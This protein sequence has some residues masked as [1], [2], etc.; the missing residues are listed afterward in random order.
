[1]SPSNDPSP[2]ALLPSVDAMLADGR[3]AGLKREPRPLLR[4]WV[5]SSLEEARTRIRA[6]IWIPRDREEAADF[7]VSGILDRSRGSLAMRLR[8]VLNATGILLHTNLGRAVLP[9]AVGRA[10]LAAAGGYSALEIDLSTGERSSRLAALRELIPLMTGAE[11]GFA[12]NN[13]AAALLL[14]MAALAR[15]REVLV[16]RGQLVEIGGSFRLPEILEAAGVILR[17]V[18]TTN[19]TRISD[20]RR[21][22]NER[23]ALVLRVHRSNFR[24][25]GFTEEPALDELAAFCR[26]EGLPLIDDLGSGALRALRD[27]FPEEPVIEESIGGGVDLVCVS[28]D[29]LL[30]IT[31]AGI[32][33]GRAEIVERI[34]RHPIARVVR[35]DKTLIAG[36]EAGLRLHLEGAEAARRTIPLL[37]ALSRPLEDLAAACARCG[38]GLAERLGEGFTITTQEVRGE[39]G[40][41]SLP[42]IDLA[43]CAVAIR[44][45]AAGAEELARRLREGDPPVVGRIRDGWLLLDLRAID[46]DDVD[47]LVDAV[48]RALEESPE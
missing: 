36:L 12:V 39:V 34:A 22:R 21:G 46:E 2:L 42:G 31:Q 47:R 28:A 13:N 11:A 38:R 10:V 6:E 44:A 9:A 35:L 16:S 27:L 48:A 26:E 19:R 45:A 5:R 14:A 17:E 8:P 24:L 3:L 40:G 20:F 30:G 37:R 4:A 33:A 32:L 15:G 29:K 41:G 25:V 7:I 18:G 1:M 43:S 23:T